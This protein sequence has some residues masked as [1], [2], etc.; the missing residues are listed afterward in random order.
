MLRNHHL[1][2]AASLLLS[3]G[4]SLQCL[5]DSALD[6]EALGKRLFFDPVLSDPPGQ[7]C[8]SCHAPQTGFADPRQT[9][10]SEGVHRGRFTR[11]N[12]PSIAYLGTVPPLHYEP[13]EE[14]YVGGFFYDGRAKGFTDQIDGPLFSPVEMA[15]TNKKQLVDRLRS[16]PY[17]REFQKVYGDNA[18]IDTDTGF[19]QLGE[20]L[21]AYQR[22]E[23]VSPFSSKYDLYLAGKVKLT[24]AEERGL[25]LYADE[26]K[27]NC[28][29]CHPHERGPEGTP[30]LFTDFTYD[31]IGVPKN[32]ASPF[33]TQ[34]TAF[35]R[36]GRDAI[37]L[38]L[39]ETVKDRQQNG[40]F[41]VTTLRNISL[42]A[43][44]MHN[45]IFATLEEVVDFYNTR[46]VDP[47]WAPPEVPENVNKEELGDLKLAD[48]EVRDIVTFLKTL[49]DGYTLA[50]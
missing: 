37:D 7:S 15:N 49:T 34:P 39:G 47:K 32:T 13:K 23:E 35:N 5:A 26:K 2:C 16:S 11:R 17:L 38:G 24:P 20:V 19:A 30:P 40:K 45:G 43:P 29:A 1:T 22:S 28:A 33:L 21:A 14:T 41:K 27:G 18:L 4:L 6:Q 31:N 50:E 44:Y 48:N 12:A 10:V 8:A 9:A 46:D 25:R 36:A 42:T 3:T